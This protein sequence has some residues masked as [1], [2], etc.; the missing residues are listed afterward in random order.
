MKTVYWSFSLGDT[1]EQTLPT[2]YT[3]PPEKFGK[4][5]DKG[6]QHAMCPA[7]KEYGKNTWCR[8]NI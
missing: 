4:D 5:Y 6:Y 3:D 8:R 1:L 2:D 7:W